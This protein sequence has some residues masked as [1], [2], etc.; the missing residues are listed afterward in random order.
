MSKELN[1]IT[2]KNIKAYIEGNSK[3]FLSKVGFQA[4]HL[5]EQV[6]YRAL[7]CKDD[8]VPQGYCQKCY[9]DLPG[10]HYVAESCNP[11][12]FPDLM[13]AKE[14]EEFKKQNNINEQELHN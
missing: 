7:M 3:M 14:W 12:R 8:C 5:K 1:R 6:A 13:S 9:C 11:E 2:I 4:E 10:K